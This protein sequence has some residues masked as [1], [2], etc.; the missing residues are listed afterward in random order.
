MSV[1]AKVRKGIICDQLF[2]LLSYHY[3]VIPCTMQVL[4]LLCI[5]LWNPETSLQT[6]KK[7]LSERS[8][9]TKEQM[10]TKREKCGTRLQFTKHSK[11]A[12]DSYQMTRSCTQL[13]NSEKTERRKV[14]N[15][16]SCALF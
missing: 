15:Q 13:T 2:L 10:R 16:R 8:K 6:H 14:T 12:L 5:D 3:E 9:K 1:P 7:T 4:I 11:Q